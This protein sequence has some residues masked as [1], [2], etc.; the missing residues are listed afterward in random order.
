MLFENIKNFYNG[1]TIFPKIGITIVAIVVLI[2]L[3]CVII[4]TIGVLGKNKAQ[5]VGEKYE[6]YVAKA[7]KKRFKHNA[8]R[9]IIFTKDNGK[10]TEMDM[11]IVTRKGIFCVE[12]K[13]RNMPAEIGNCGVVKATAEDDIWSYI[14]E[15]NRS[16]PLLDNPLKQN[17]GHIKELTS[18][19][20]N[21]KCYNVVVINKLIKY[22]STTTGGIGMG[23]LYCNPEKDANIIV[24]LGEYYKTKSLKMLAKEF[25]N[26]PDVYTDAEVMSIENELRKYKA[27]KK[28]RKQH[29]AQF[30]DNEDFSE[31]DDLF[32]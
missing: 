3:V 27:T 10:T 30:T 18:H 29:A 22:Y 20:A 4:S 21:A 9:N 19:I 32:K 12:C 23:S 25:K 6:K 13:H 31:Y 8:I 15:Y 1:L 7:F 24:T 17:E 5:K 11:A 16:Y 28:Q 26:M 2:S 14:D